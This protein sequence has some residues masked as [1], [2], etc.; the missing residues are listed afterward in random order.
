MTTP[1]EPPPNTQWAIF[2]DGSVGKW[3][4]EGD[5]PPPLTGPGR[6]VSE[7][8]YLERLGEIQAAVEERRAATEAA[9]QETAK[10]AY[11]A[12]IAAGIPEASA[13]HLSRYDGPEPDGTVP[14]HS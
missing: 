13:R 5:T 3:Q 4:Y 6:L 2:E 11:E 10:S 9:E 8:E 7:N 12:L 14:V 1:V